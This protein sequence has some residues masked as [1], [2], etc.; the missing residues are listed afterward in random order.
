MVS[1]QPMAHACPSLSLG[2]HE[3]SGLPCRVVRR[4]RPR[5]S[6][7]PRTEAVLSTRGVMP[8]ANLQV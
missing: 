2:I 1:L 4:P 5:G 7:W 6:G 8:G 3:R